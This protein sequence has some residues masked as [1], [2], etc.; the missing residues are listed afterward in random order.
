MPPRVEKCIAEEEG[1]KKVKAT[2]L[3]GMCVQPKPRICGCDPFL[4]DLF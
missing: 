2:Q 1:G 3:H 4:S